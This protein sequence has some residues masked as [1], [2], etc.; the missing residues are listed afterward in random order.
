MV[1]YYLL[2][3]GSNDMMYK[4]FPV[5]ICLT[6]RIENIKCET[7]STVRLQV[8]NLQL[9]ILSGKRIPQWDEQSSKVYLPI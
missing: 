4:S 7:D 9:L 8:Q 2:Q 5:Y 6:I 3:L 1:T